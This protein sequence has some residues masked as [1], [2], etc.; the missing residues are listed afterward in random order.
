MSQGIPTSLPTSESENLA[1]ACADE[2]PQPAAPRPA[3]SVT[4]WWLLDADR[5]IEGDQAD[6]RVHVHVDRAV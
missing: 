4:R 1:V 6:T 3:D 5:V 2:Q